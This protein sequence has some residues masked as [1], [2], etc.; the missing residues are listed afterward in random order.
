MVVV[1]MGNDNF[2][3]LPQDCTESLFFVALLHCKRGKETNL[4]YRDTFD[5]RG[6]APPCTSTA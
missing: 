1:M 2:T 6:L 4:G 5:T 3:A